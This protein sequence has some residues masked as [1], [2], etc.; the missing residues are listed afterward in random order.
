MERKP[1]P[2][3]RP[4][5]SETENSYCLTLEHKNDY[6]YRIHQPTY[7]TLGI[8]LDLFLQINIDFKLLNIT[9]WCV[10]SFGFREI[11]RVS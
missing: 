1:V 6:T 10:S 8:D 4:L 2:I 3:T 11:I 7:R 9:F 5:V